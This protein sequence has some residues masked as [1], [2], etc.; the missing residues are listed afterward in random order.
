M[1]EEKGEHEL[2]KGGGNLKD[3]Y[4]GSKKGSF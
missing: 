2:F 4:S 1:I 3:G